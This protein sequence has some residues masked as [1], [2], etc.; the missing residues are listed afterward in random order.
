MT[1][2][3]T[4]APARP[5]VF[6]VG[7]MRSGTTLL[8][9]LLHAHPDLAIFCESFLF[10]SSF[11]LGRT[12]PKLNLADE[13]HAWASF[14]LEGYNP[15]GHGY[16]PVLAF[17]DRPGLRK[18]LRKPGQSPD[19]WLSVLFGAWMASQG[20]HSWGD[21]STPLQAGE[22][23]E[24]HRLFPD[25]RFIHIHRDPRGVAHSIVEAGWAPNLAAGAAYWRVAMK[26][27][28]SGLATVPPDQVHEISYRN[29]CMAPESMLRDLCSFLGEHSLL[30]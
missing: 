16:E 15:Y 24:M 10:R 28:R 23:L 17:L 12:R 30:R 7:C 8:G 6:I 14:L 2:R 4:E 21:K 22:I 11:V 9:E 25:A 26:S 13:G 20:A 18:E 5:P 29:L 1:G 3:P 27:I 19:S